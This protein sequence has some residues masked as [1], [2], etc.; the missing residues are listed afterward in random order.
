MITNDSCLN[1]VL[2]HLSQAMIIHEEELPMG[3]PKHIYRVF[4][5]LAEAS[6]E[7]IALYP[8]LAN[9]IRGHRLAL[10]DDRSRVIPYQGLLDYTEM[11][12]TC[13]DQNLPIPGVPE[14]L[15][16]QDAKPEHKLVPS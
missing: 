1:C 4:G 3:Y 12:L 7:S 15:V 13:L 9:A 10:L 6:R 2:K 16:V 8:G 11:L 14:D 5:H